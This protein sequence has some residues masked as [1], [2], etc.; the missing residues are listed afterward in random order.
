MAERRIGRARKSNAADATVRLTSGAGIEV[1]LVGRGAAIQAIRVSGRNQIVDVA[2]GYANATDYQSDPF[3]LGATIGRY[4]GRINAGRCTLDGQQLQLAVNPSEHGHCLHGGPGGLHSQMWQPERE[5]DGS[6]AVYRTHSEDGDQGFPGSL[7]LAV[8]YS[9]TDSTLAIAY[10]CVSDADT[11]LNLSNHTYFNLAGT[12]TIHDHEIVINA[13]AY[14]PIN[15]ANIPTG[16]IRSVTGTRFD[17]RQP[18]RLRDCNAGRPPDFDNN[19]VLNKDE[20]RRMNIDSVAA[21]FAASI[22]SLVSGIRMNV[23]TSQPGLQF[24]AGQY[25]AGPFAPY[26]GLCLEAQRFPDAP[27]HPAFP[28]AVLRAGEEYRE[29]I[30][31][32]FETLSG[33]A[34]E[35]TLGNR[36]AAAATGQ[37]YQ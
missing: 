23:Y 24:Y 21:A 30:V 17:L 16:E 7:D 10:H 31:Y 20:A 19:F 26:R 1:D 13:D 35:Q 29:V 15:A 12:G 8:R 9:L 22:S 37:T 11:I 4:A 32:E 33:P 6:A 5:P 14:T 27:N 28:S 18:R 34:D 25:L 3:Y 2:L 36:A